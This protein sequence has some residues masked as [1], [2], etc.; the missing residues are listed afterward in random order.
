MHGA[1]AEVA[2]RAVSFLWLIPAL[3]ALG[4]LFHVFLG[5]HLGKRAVS[6]VGPG[7]VGGSLIVAA[8]AFG[9]I[10]S[11]AP[12]LVLHQ[13]LWT[14]IP[15]GTLEVPFALRVDALSA[16]MILVVTGVGFLIHV[17]SVGYMH[18]DPGYARY[19]AY[20]N[21]FTV[22]MLLLVMADNLL[23]L[24]V[25]WEG[26]GLCSYLLIGFWYDNDA[27]ASAGKKAFIVNRVGD[28]AF[29]IGM[30][31]LFWNLG[32]GTHSLSFT[33]IAR[34]AQSLSP[35]VVTAVTLLLFVGA[36]GKSAQLPLYVWLPDAMAGP[37]PVSALIHAAT[38]VTAGVYMIARLHAL[39][40]LAPI[41]LGVVATIGALTAVFAAT[42][43]LVQTDIKKVL[44]YSTISQ[45]GYMF[46]AVGVGAFSAGIFHL[47]THAFFKAL[48]F[49]GSGSVIHGMGGEQDIRKMGGLRGYMP[50]T[51][52]TF[53]VGTL[54]IAGIPGFAG[55]FSK[56][57][58]LAQ[59][60]ASSPFLWL[61]GLCGAA[62]TAFYMFRLFF[63]VFW[64]DC[65]AA[66]HT[67]SHLHESP[68]TMTVPLIVLAV[69]SVVGGYVGLPPVFA[70]GDQFGAFL[71]PVFS[72][73]HPSEHHMPVS[74]EL[75]LMAA[76]VGVA[77]LGI[78]LAYQLYVV[79]PARAE[80]WAA[81]FPRLYRVLLNKYY[82]DELY[83]TVFV[84]PTVQLAHFLW[85]QFDVAVVDG[86]VNGAGEAVGET[87]RWLRR[88]QTGNVQHYALSLLVGTLLLLGYFLGLG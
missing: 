74:V 36:T 68:S 7:V 88:W 78:W 8:A 67:R 24:F 18:D 55:F 56:D 2:T 16:V 14:W 39:Y 53:L 19:F 82:V 64:G 31:L 23:L 12:G 9:T 83:D 6:I 28:A 32:P 29:L 63:L 85:R 76:S 81:E 5:R 54:A 87:G 4:V 13:S 50:I 35:A 38:M 46:L 45:L 27:N 79:A 80:R 43:G 3:P 62:L 52:A 84:R 51:Y 59:A 33:E 47:M 72:A 77:V 26:V 44:A 11:G 66:A 69:L 48:L 58:I 25:G 1:E 22:A 86:A 61:L 73:A 34:Q 41:S 70:W 65:R 49:L 30:F 21:L 75:A 17:Y 57:M 60:F 10:W 20:L 37:T 42:I 15:A 40:V 71:A